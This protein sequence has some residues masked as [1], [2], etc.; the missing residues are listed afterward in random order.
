MNSI[1]EE[2]VLEVLDSEAPLKRFQGRQKFRKWLNDEVKEMMQERDSWK[3]IA[4][5]SGRY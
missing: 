4:R 1:F 3:T 5:I 2:K